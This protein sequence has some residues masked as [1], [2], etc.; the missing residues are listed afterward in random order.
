[1]KGKRIALALLALILALAAMPALAAE[2]ALYQV[3]E[4]SIDNGGMNIYA[5]CYI[6]QGEGTYPTVILAHGYGGT[7]AYVE[8]YAQAIAQAGYACCIFDFCGGG[9]ASQSDG[10]MAEMTVS[11]E[12]ADLN[13]ILDEVKGLDFVDADNLFLFGESQGGFVSALVAAQRPEDVRALVLLYPAFVIPD[14][15]RLG[16]EGAAQVT[17]MTFSQAYIDDGATYDP[18]AH[19]A[20]YDKNVLI[21]H[22]D[23]DTLVPIAYSERAVEAY[24]SARLIVVEGAGH[25]YSDQYKPGVIGHCI[26]FLNDNL[27]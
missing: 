10:D 8:P 14:N 2:G 16:L 6:P 3:E 18:Y 24:Q 12:A 25:G 15:C 19:I 20:P 1:M 4:M 5:Q 22:G 26:D 23:R 17:G 7:H 21:L 9:R 13:A 27:V 11:S